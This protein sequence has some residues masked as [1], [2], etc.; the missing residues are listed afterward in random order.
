MSGLTDKAKNLILFV[1]LVGV[2]IVAEGLTVY[3]INKWF[4]SNAWFGFTL[5]GIDLRTF[6]FG[7]LLGIL[8]A[9]IVFHIWE[10]SDY[11]KWK[12]ENKH[13]LR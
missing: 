1:F 12:N 13:W 8:Y 9:W 10:W 5:Y 3:L 11:K 6:F 2:W 4:L 7:W